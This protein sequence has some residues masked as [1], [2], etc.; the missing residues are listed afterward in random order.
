MNQPTETMVTEEA[1]ANRDMA[2]RIHCVSLA[3]TANMPSVSVTFD[4][5]ATPLVA[6]AFYEFIT[7]AR[8]DDNLDLVQVTK[9]STDGDLIVPDFKTIRRSPLDQS[10]E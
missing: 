8:L 2:M 5:Y 9:Y 1:S 3:M 7:G 4:P 10:K 6:Q